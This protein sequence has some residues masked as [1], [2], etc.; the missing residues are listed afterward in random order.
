V[1]SAGTVHSPTILMHSG[2]G[3]AEQLRQHG[4]AVIVR[5]WAKISRTTRW[6]RSVP[7]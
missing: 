1:L 5:R 3:P 4:I 6:Y 2:V 7:M